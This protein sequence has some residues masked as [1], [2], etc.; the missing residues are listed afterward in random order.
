MRC[1]DKPSSLRDKTNPDWAPSQYLG[2][3]LDEENDI[4]QHFPGN[5]L[6]EERERL[7]DSSE[8]L[9]ALSGHGQTG[10]AVESTD[11]AERQINSNTCEQEVQTNMAMKEIEDIETEIG[12]LTAEKG[13]LKAKLKE[14]SLDE[15]AFMNDNKRVLF[16][17][18]LPNWMLLSAVF[19]LVQPFLSQSARYVFC[20]HFREC[21]SL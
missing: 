2:C 18:G 8:A 4:Q 13:A 1:T 6:E 16:Y 20:H 9:L 15:E 17:T 5:G 7:S 3:Q 19:N 21:L 11:T 14:M 12:R 10:E